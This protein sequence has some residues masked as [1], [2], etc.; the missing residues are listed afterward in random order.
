VASLTSA[1]F[2]IGYCALLTSGEVDCWGEGDSGQLG[3]GIFYT[4]GHEGSAVPVA[5]KAVDGTGTL[6]FVSGLI[7]GYYNS[8]ARL[9]S[10]RV[11]CWG[12]GSAGQLGNGSLDSSALPVAVA[13]VGGV[14]KLDR[15]AGL[16][17]GTALSSC[18]LLTSGEVDCWGSGSA[19][20]LGNGKFYSTGGTNHGSDTPVVV[21][22]IGG[23][24]ALGE[25][26]GLSGG[27]DN[28]NSTYCA[29]LTSGEVD[30]WGYGNN[31]Q[32]G[33]GKFYTTGHEGSATPVKVIT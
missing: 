32:L 4:T 27:N 10:G 25:V 8:C 20:Q 31:G 7:S 30:C 26:A 28:Y 17:D 23:T 3:N 12:L 24:G 11:D 33:N 9:T 15:V 19:G 14:G 16:I 13:G 1:G 2:D 18:A 5:V 6:R 29:S 22:G 21:D